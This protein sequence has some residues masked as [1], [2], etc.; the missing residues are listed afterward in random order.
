MQCFYFFDETHICSVVICAQT[1]IHVIHIQRCAQQPHH[2][3]I[4]TCYVNAHPFYSSLSRIGKGYLVSE[5]WLNKIL[6]IMNIF[7]Q[8]LDS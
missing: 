4:K 8:K 2:G 3:V 7:L 5:L 1:E 6:R